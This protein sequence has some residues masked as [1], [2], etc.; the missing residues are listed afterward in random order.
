MRG[1][2]CGGLRRTRRLSPK[3]SGVEPLRPWR[4]WARRD[5]VI[6]AILLV[7]ITGVFVVGLLKRRDKTVLRMGYDALAAILLSASRLG[8][9]ARTME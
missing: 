9:L 5:V 3:R 7:M 4:D 2:G 6:G 8:L 1:S